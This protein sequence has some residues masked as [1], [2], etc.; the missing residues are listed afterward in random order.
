MLPLELSIVLKVPSNA[1]ALGGACP[2]SP[3]SRLLSTRHCHPSD[4]PQH[5]RKADK[6]RLA[7]SIFR[8]RKC[9]LQKVD[10]SEGMWLASS[11]TRL[12]TSEPHR[13]LLGVGAG[14]QE[15]RCWGPGGVGR[16]R[17][18]ERGPAGAPHPHGFPPHCDSL[19]GPF[20]HSHI[21]SFLTASRGGLVHRERPVSRLLFCRLTV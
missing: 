7:W 10:F 4:P 13:T 19:E 11:Q 21:H 15:P 18:K 3:R 12:W 14:E 8:M 6:A 16:R 20:T 9:R 17:K 1:D 2:Q 5:P